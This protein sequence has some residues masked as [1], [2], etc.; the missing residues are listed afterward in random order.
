MTIDRITTHPGEILREEFLSPLGMSAH[1]LAVA[2]KVP[3]SRISEIVKERRGVSVDTAVR[4]AKYFGMS[5]DFWLNLQR[6]YDISQIKK[7]KCFEIEHI[8]PYKEKHKNSL[9]A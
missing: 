7:E 6:N 9:Y 3:A 8:I 5:A 1:A 4:L 2:I